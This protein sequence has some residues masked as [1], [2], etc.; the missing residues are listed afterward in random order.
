MAMVAMA[1]T[2]TLAI[3]LETAVQEALV[4]MEEPAALPQVLLPTPIPAQEVTAATVA[5]VETVVTVAIIILAI[6][7]ATAAPAALVAEVE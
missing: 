4:E 1:A 5:V 2:T 3:T 7:P 6:T